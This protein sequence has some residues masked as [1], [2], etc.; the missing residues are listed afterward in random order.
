MTESTPEVDDETL[1]RVMVAVH[2]AVDGLPR[3]VAAHL[4][5]ASALH[6]TPASDV[7]IL[8]RACISARAWEDVK[9]GG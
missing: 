7:Y 3:E 2:Q 5:M 9:R 8:L 4:L 6:Y 1:T